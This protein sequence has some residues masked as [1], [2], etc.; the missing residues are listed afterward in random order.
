MSFRLFHQPRK[1]SNSDYVKKMCN[2]EKFQN[3][4]ILYKDPIHGLLEDY[5]DTCFKIR[6]CN[7]ITSIKDYNIL[8]K[9]NVFY[10]HLSVDICRNII[11]NFNYTINNSN[12]LK[13]DITAD[14]LVKQLKNS[15]DL[16][17]DYIHSYIPTSTSTNT[18]NLL[19]IDPSNLVFNTPNS[20]TNLFTKNT[21]SFNYTVDNSSNIIDDIESELLLCKNKLIKPITTEIRNIL[22]PA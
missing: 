2:R 12:Y 10:N 19:I 18:N 20:C 17:C 22:F 21:S 15:Q 14:C 5:T 16:S 13:C 3:I 6:P 8:Q 1:D 7:Q 4:T 11:Q 9:Y